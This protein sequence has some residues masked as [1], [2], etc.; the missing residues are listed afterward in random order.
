MTPQT[1]PRQTAT[2]PPEPR[3]DWTAWSLHFLAGVVAGGIAGMF[4]GFRMIRYAFIGGTELLLAIAGIAIFGGAIASYRGEDTWTM[5]SAL[6]PQRPQQGRRCRAWSKALGGG[7]AA[8]VAGAVIWHLWTAGWAGGHF[9]WSIGEVILL[10]LG[11]FVAYLVVRALR[12]GSG[13][14][15]FGPPDRDDASFSFW[16]WVAGAGLVLLYLVVRIL[17]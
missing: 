8:L 6:D 14:W 16:L 9:S 4:L 12:T 2:Q 7:S 13:W 5:R 3:D 11:V 1:E 10:L 17:A 15:I